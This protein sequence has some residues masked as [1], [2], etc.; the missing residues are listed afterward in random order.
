VEDQGAGAKY[1]KWPRHENCLKGLAGTEFGLARGF[2]RN[3]FPHLHMGPNFCQGKNK[4]RDKKDLIQDAV[5]GHRH[6]SENLSAIPNKWVSLLR[7]AKAWALC[8]AGIAPAI[9]DCQATLEIEPGKF[10]NPFMITKNHT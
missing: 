5:P 1:E 9:K 3:N 10:I 6:Q 2:F 8:W 4:G 7:W